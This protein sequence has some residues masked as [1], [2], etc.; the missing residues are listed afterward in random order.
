MKI[1]NFGSLNIDYTYDVPH[2]VRKGETL[3]AG[4]L[5]TF[6]GGKGLNQSIALKKSGAQVWH[7]GAVGKDDGQLL[8]DALAGAGVDVSLIR[9]VD[10]R[11]GHA[12]VQ[13]DASGENCIILFGGAN[14]MLT[15]SQVD[16]ALEK[17]EAGDIL[18]VQNE[19]NLV[20][21][22]MKKAHAKGMQI[23]F[24]AAPMDANA[25]ACPLDLVDYFVLNESEAEAIARAILAKDPKTKDAARI[26]MRIIHNANTALEQELDLLSVIDKE[27]PKA[28]LVLTVGE[29]GAVYKDGDNIYEQGIYHVP[30]ADT[31]G[32]GDT[33][34][35]FFLGMTAA[36]KRPMEALRIAAK[37]AAICVSREGAAVSIPTLEEVTASKI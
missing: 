9:K 32:A 27:Y 10:G 12:I 29:D 15:E 22:I 8:V 36:G 28:K 4:E 14:Q 11:S 1:L 21:Y 26:D 34:T 31:T 13:K 17:F 35:G 3:L 7:A 6:C 18:L 20:G 16:G 19:T 30:V 2:F 33:F 37:A 24:N 25:L 23:V 5:Q